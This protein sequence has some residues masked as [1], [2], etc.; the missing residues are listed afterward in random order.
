MFCGVVQ[1]PIASMESSPSIGGGEARSSVLAETAQGEGEG[2]EPMMR[3]EAK[4]L[5][6]DAALDDVK[7]DTEEASDE[8][9]VGNGTGKGE[10]DRGNSGA[11]QGGA[12]GASDEEMKESAE[13]KAE[14]LS[15]SSDRNTG[16]WAE[17]AE[18]DEERREVKGRARSTPK[19]SA[20][21]GAFQ[22]GSRAALSKVHLT[23]SVFFLIQYVAVWDNLLIG[24]Q[25]CRARVG[26][27]EKERKSYRNRRMGTKKKWAMYM[28]Y[29]LMMMRRKRRTTVR[30]EIGIDTDTA[31][32]S[33]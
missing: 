28:I 19:A 11:S 29:R 17:N 15:N 8:P 21:K 33:S 22:P 27:E 31:S 16:G 13:Q 3:A 10:R 9:R 26:T 18:D 1:V 2:E 5:A 14:G 20:H 12:Q 23:A 30:R 4:P 6:S 32:S 7:I 24:D 25:K